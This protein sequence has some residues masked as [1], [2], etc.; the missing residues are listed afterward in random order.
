[1]IMKRYK[2]LS[3][4][5]RFCFASSTRTPEVLESFVDLANSSQVMIAP[6]SQARQRSQA[7]GAECREGKGRGTQSNTAGPWLC[8]VLPMR[9]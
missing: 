4:A 2:E 1:M 5:V 6:S 8:N 9:W 3:S 7:L